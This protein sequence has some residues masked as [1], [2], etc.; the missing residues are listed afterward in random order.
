MSPPFTDE[1]KAAMRRVEKML[2]A[3]TIALGHDPWRNGALS[4]NR[5][6]VVARWVA[7]SAS[8]RKPDLLR[9]L[10]GAVFS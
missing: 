1:E 10:W 9:R 7:T 4:F 5:P 3:G 6:H 8:K 2:A